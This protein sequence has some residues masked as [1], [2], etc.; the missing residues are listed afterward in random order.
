MAFTLAD[1][2]L[3]GEAKEVFRDFFVPASRTNKTSNMHGLIIDDSLFVDTVVVL[4]RS[5]ALMRVLQPMVYVLS[6]GIS[7]LVAYLGIRSRRL[8]LAVMRSLGAKSLAIYAEV[9]CEHIL[10]FLVGTAGA[11]LVSTL[12]GIPAKMGDI[13]TV[14]AFMVCYLL[15]V[16]LAVA[17]A[18]SGQIMQTL[19]GKE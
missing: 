11:Y 3:L 13:S 18:T 16:A 7:F 1:N 8:E 17:Q 12:W 10:F 15:G 9:L 19:K 5:L 2:H 14:G 6:V 4:E